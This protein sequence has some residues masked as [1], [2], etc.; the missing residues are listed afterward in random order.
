MPIKPAPLSPTSFDSEDTEAE[1]EEDEQDE[2][3]EQA[4][5]FEYG[6]DAAG[7]DGQG[8]KNMLVSAVEGM[9]EEK[10]ASLIM[11]ARAPWFE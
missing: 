5:A 10:A 1:D 6:I 2:E 7:L 4:E 11:T 8:V 9:N 3:A